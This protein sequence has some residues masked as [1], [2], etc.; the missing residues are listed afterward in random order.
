MERETYS[1]RE[2]NLE[3]SPKTY[4]AINRHFDKGELPEEVTKAY[5]EYMILI[6]PLHLQMN[7]CDICKKMISHLCFHKDCTKPPPIREVELTLEE[8]VSRKFYQTYRPVVEMKPRPT[9]EVIRDFPKGALTCLGCQRRGH[10][11][12]QCHQLLAVLK[13]GASPWTPY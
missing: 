6:D 3:E 8:E 13:G 4:Q 2:K 1:P 10:I 5:I 9:M 7:I 11:M 12:T